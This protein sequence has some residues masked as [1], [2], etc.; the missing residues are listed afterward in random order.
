MDRKQ[1]GLFDKLI[2][3][4]EQSIRENSICEKEYVIHCPIAFKRA[5]WPLVYV[6]RLRVTVG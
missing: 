6:L 3:D 2:K 4:F 5:I 1:M